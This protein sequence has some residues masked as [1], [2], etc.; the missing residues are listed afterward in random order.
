MGSEGVPAVAPAPS[1]LQLVG[2]KRLTLR[3]LRSYL[4]ITRWF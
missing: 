1:A 3:A 4:G 2:E